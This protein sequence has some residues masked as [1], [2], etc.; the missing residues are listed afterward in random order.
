MNP[1]IDISSV[2]LHTARLTLRPWRQE[3]LDDFYAYASVDGVGQMAGW[4]PHQ[5]KAE[6]QTIL[7]L[8][9]RQKKTFA[10][11]Y[12]NQVIGSLGIECYDEE[13]HPNLAPWRGREIGYVLAKPFWGRGLAT[14]AARAA[15]D[16]LFRAEDL[17]FLIAGHSLG[18]GDREVRLPVSEHHPLRNPVRHHR[19]LGGEHPVEPCPARRAVTAY[20]KG[21]RSARTPF[22]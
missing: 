22:L 9:I 2:V 1:P 11:Q 17:D 5:S 15:I 10:L 4:L 20:R 16:Y 7:D 12:Q 13:Q 14:E 6:T 3:D 18:E 21:A 8:F 19:N